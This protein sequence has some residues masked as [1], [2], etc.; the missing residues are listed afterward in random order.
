MGWRVHRFLLGHKVI[1]HE[2]IDQSTYYGLVRDGTERM[3]T[4]HACSCGHIWA[5][6]S[7]GPRFTNWARFGTAQKKLAALTLET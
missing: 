7:L 3:I 1:R 5:S 2:R 4:H 6:C